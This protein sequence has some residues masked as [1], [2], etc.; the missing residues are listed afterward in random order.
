LT[1]ASNAPTERAAV[2]ILAGTTASGKTGVS[3]P[4]ATQLN[5]EIINADSRQVYKELIIGTAR[6]ASEQLATV[7]HHFVGHL[8]I[9][10]RWTAGDFGSE[11]RKKIEEILLR[12][13]TPVV[14]G[15]SML[16]LR[17]LMDGFYAEDTG[18]DISY[19]HLREELAQRGAESM[20]RELQKNDPD[21]A[22]RTNPNDHERIL[23]GLAVYRET[24]I[25]LTKLQS[26][27]ATKLERPFKLY[28]LYGD[29][30]ETY[31]RADRRVLQMIE[32]G[33][34]DEVKALADAGFDD[35]N[36]QALRTHG[37]QEVFP[38]LRG[39]ISR[40]DMIAS[41][42]KAVRHYIKRQLTW[43]RKDTRAIWIERNFSEP[44]D[45][46]TGR[47]ATDFQA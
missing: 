26:K 5:G 41:I 38:Y 43:F 24:G 20:Y 8:S 44:D 9:S 42:Q 32:D 27:P 25:P 21:L 36:T 14:V 6:P 30:K 12:G 19:M 37:Y 10:D 11:A 35:S 47:I 16:Y 18:R 39:D 17:S 13:K 7:P 23:R 33:L 29:R 45:A 34:V 22:D 40:D 2:L 28:F 1:A 46:V 4:L 3:I 31:S 15:G